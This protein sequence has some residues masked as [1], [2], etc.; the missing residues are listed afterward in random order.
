MTPRQNGALLTIGTTTIQSLGLLGHIKTPELEHHVW[1]QSLADVGALYG[2]CDQTVRRE[3]LRRGIATPPKGW[4]QSD[5]M[6][7]T[8]APDKVLI[9]KREAWSEISSSDLELLLE[10]QTA[11]AIGLMFCISSS[12]VKKKAKKL[13]LPTKPRGYW[14]HNQFTSDLLQSRSKEGLRT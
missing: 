3:C 12:A 6:N 4:S 10:T 2:V 11:V 1:S 14:G 5:S 8:S 13:K 9:A 7:S